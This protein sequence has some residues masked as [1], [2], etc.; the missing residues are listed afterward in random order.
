MLPTGRRPRLRDVLD[1]LRGV[2]G[3]DHS[4]ALM[5]LTV[6]GRRD[7]WE[8]SPSGWPRVQETPADHVRLRSGGR[9]VPRCSRLGTGRSDDLTPAP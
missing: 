3:V 2:E 6:Y 9:P 7:L 4:H 8:G 1:D 5:D